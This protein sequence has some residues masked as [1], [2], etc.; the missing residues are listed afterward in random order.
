MIMCKSDLTWAL[1]HR[2]FFQ[3]QIKMALHRATAALVGLIMYLLPSHA[4]V[5][6]VSVAGECSKTPVTA[7][8]ASLSPC[9]GAAKSPHGKVPPAGGSRVGALLRKVADSGFPFK[10]ADNF[11]NIG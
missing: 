8:A 9:A 5:R 10:W 11:P 1:K 2:A 7:A 6:G 4:Y 3:Q